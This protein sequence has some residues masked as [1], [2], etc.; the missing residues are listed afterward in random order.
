LGPEPTIRIVN[1]AGGSLTPAK[2]VTLHI[3]APLRRLQHDGG[4]IKLV[5]Y[6][7]EAPQMHPLKAMMG[8]QVRKAH[9]DFALVAG[10]AQW[11]HGFWSMGLSIR[12]NIEPTEK[13][14]A[15]TRGPLF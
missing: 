6:A 1:V 3:F 14:P 8:L 5:T 13:P 2:L 4:E 7:G 15:L 10:F 9:R 12:M 11:A